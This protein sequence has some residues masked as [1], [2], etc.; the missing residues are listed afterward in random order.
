MVVKDFNV[1]STMSLEDM[2][3]AINY[4]QNKDIFEAELQ[5]IKEKITSKE[6]EKSISQIKNTRTLDS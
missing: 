6:K 5:E 1:R 2:N 4:L 3:L